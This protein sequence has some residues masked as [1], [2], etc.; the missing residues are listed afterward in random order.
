[1]ILQ[2]E[3]VESM[4]SN[5]TRQLINELYFSLQSEDFCFYPIQG[6]HIYTR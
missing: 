1:M 4:S 6:N 3:M 5:Y 2:Y